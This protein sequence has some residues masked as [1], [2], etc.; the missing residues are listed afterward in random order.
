[1]QNLFLVY[2]ENGRETMIRLAILTGLSGVMISSGNHRKRVSS[3]QHC[4]NRGS[5]HE[6]DPGIDVE[7][8][9]RVK[10]L[11]AM[12][13][14]S[15]SS[16]GSSCSRLSY[17]SENK[18]IPLGKYHVSARSMEDFHNTVKSLLQHSVAVDV[19]CEETSSQDQLSYTCDM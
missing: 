18:H 6:A 13:N 19:H 10:D 1:M 7:L 9:G 16:K 11:S 15:L 8:K 2:V 12:V 3:P 5:K 14:A 4:D 17:D